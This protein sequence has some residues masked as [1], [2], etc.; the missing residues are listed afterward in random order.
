MRALY[1][2]GEKMIDFTRNGKRFIAGQGFMS[3][4]DAASGNKEMGVMDVFRKVDPTPEMC[5]SLYSD[6]QEIINKREQKPKQ[7]KART[8]D[9]F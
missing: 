2:D 4:F 3:V 5:I 1:G 8:K 7:T 6:M 9:P